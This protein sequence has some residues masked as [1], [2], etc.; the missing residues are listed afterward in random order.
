MKINLPKT[1]LR[2]IDRDQY[3]SKAAATIDPGQSGVH[4]D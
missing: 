4:R 2:V 3:P 1:E